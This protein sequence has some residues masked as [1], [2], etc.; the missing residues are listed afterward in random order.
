M[1]RNRSSLRLKWRLVL[2]YR[3]WN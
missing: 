1:V 2:M 3:Y